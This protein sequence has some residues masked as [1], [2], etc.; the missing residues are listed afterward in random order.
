MTASEWR[1]ETAAVDG[2]VDALLAGDGPAA[3]RAVR[4]I[5]DEDEAHR[6][7]WLRVAMLVTWHADHGAD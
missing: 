1:A 5:P 7:V 2:I 4:E 6:R 3:A